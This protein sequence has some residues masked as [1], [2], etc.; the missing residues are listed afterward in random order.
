MYPSV[1]TLRITYCVKALLFLFSFSSLSSLTNLS[2]LR[3]SILHDASHI[4]NG[5]I[6][7]LFPVVLLTAAVFMVIQILI[8]I[9]YETHRESA[10]QEQSQNALQ[11]RWWFYTDTLFFPYLPEAGEHSDWKPCTL[12]WCPAG[13]R[14]WSSCLRPSAIP[15]SWLSYLEL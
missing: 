14:R 8:S 13:R 2:S 15:H 7:V 4:S 5:K 11:W 1:R 3:N 12:Q 6:Y 9:I 10:L